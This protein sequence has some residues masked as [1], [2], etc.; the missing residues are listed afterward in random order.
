MSTS[1]SNDSKMNQNTAAGYET[2]KGVYDGIP[3]IAYP[4]TPGFTPD[5]EVMVGGEILV[6]APV[7]YNTYRRTVKLVVRNIGDRP[8]QIGSHFL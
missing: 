4:N 2:P 1:N 3:P 5:K 7:E 8:I 6:D